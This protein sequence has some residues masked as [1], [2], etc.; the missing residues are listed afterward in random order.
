M[1]VATSSRTVA[2]TT[3]QLTIGDVARQVGVTVETLRYYEA[4]G[5]LPRVSRTRAGRRRYDPDVLAR[6]TFIKQAQALGLSLRDI[7][8]ITGRSRR[9]SDPRE[10]CRQVCGILMRQLASVTQQ[11]A[12]LAEARQTLEAYVSACERALREPDGSACPALSPLEGFLAPVFDCGV[13]GTMS[14]SHSSTRS[15]K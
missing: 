8:T 5:L 2:R 13:D 10:K 7:Q 3:T 4:L 14:Q 11:L 12:E 1:C 6:I 15:R 9:T